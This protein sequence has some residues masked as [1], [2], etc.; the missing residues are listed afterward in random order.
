MNQKLVVT[1]TLLLLVLVMPAYPTGGSIHDIRVPIMTGEEISL[2][3]Y[4]GRVLLIVNT[5]SRCGFTGQYAG[6]Q[7]LFVRYR[8]RGFTVLAFPSNSFNQELESDEEIAAFCEATFGTT[9]P[10]FSQIPVRG[11]D[12]HPLFAHLTTA[13][14]RFRGPVTWNFNKFLVGRDGRLI[15]RFDSR[16]EPTDPR[17]IRAIETALETQ[18]ESEAL[19]RQ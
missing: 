18:A 10:I 12:I 9:F 8:D 1:V 17:V 7:E 19:R 11:S 2:S 15:D 6:L 5:A 16:V 13:A 14:P 3:R 4:A